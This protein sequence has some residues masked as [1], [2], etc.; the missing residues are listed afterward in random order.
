MVFRIKTIWFYLR[1]LFVCQAGE[2]SVILAD[3][4]SKVLLGVGEIHG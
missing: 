4:L 1:K 2:D 3:Q